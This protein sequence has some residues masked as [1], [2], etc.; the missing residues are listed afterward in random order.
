M[1]EKQRKRMLP[2]VEAGT[3]LRCRAGPLCT[4]VRDDGQGL[5]PVSVIPAILHLSWYNL[6]RI[7]AGGT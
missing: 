2:R 7:T 3:C 5:Y 6:F 4:Q 1:A